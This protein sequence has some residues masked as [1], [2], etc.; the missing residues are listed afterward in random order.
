[1]ARILLVDDDPDILRVLAATFESAGHEVHATSNPDLAGPLARARL[2]DAVVLDVMMPRRSGWEVLEDLRAD[3]RTERLPVLMLSAIGDAPNRVRGLRLGADD[4][5]PKPFHPE[6]IVVRIEAMVDRRAMEQQGLQGDFAT[7]TVPDVLQT[8]ENTTA[9][10]ELEFS[11]PGGEGTLRFASGRCT[12]AEFAGLSGS[13][14]VLALLEQRAGSFRLHPERGAGDTVAELPPLTSLLFVSAW[15]EDELRAHGAALPAEDRGLAAAPG[16]V[17]PAGPDVLPELPLAAV[18][19]ELA[20]RPGTTLAE[21]VT[22]RLAAP[23]RVRLALA[24]LVEAQLV[25]AGS[26]SR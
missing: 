7:L 9:S 21:L 13:E 19:A 25:G 1:M 15:I 2:F 18:L 5:L 4:F 14:A 23:A 3:R 8:L 26:P 6:E 16:A 11:T 12:A 24:L 17:A 20:A 10:G 22:M